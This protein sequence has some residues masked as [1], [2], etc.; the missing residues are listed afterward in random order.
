MSV[1]ALTPKVP[2]LGRSPRTPLHLP[3]ICP[4]GLPHSFLPV[5]SQRGALTEHRKGP[6]HCISICGQPGLGRLQTVEMSTLS[7]APFQNPEGRGLA[8]LHMTWV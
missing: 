1:T 2:S 3:R 8:S 5:A 7:L 6:V 4:A